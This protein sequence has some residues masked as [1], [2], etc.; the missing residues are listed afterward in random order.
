MSDEKAVVATTEDP[1]AEEI[2][3]KENVVDVDKPTIEEM[4][5]MLNGNEDIFEGPA[6]YKCSLPGCA[7]HSQL[8]SEMEEHVSGTGHGGYKSGPVQP[9]LFSEHGE[10][11]R[12][13]NVPLPDGVVTEKLIELSEL[14]QD[15]LNV[16]ENKK[17]ADDEFNAQL[18]TLDAQ[19]QAIARILKTPWTSEPVKCIWRII[20]GEN[21]RGLY[22]IDTGEIID[23]QPL[24]AEDR[25]AELAQA[26]AANAAPVEAAPAE[27]ISEAADSGASINERYSGRKK[28]KATPASE[29]A[30][31]EPGDE[32][33]DEQPEPD[34]DAA[35]AIV[36]E[37][38]EEERPRADP[39]AGE[40]E[41]A[42][43][44]KR[45]RRRAAVN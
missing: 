6:G 11:S 42:G 22:R 8:L 21:A 15:T 31:E 23:K 17:A 30:T 34:T 41:A 3:G 2:V 4:S 40:L 14:Y 38:Q 39:L 18:K 12:F 45:R 28:R 35:S 29:Q 19:M 1:T 36:D 37:M 44:G 13:V 24:T 27:P 25:A 9:E 10:V 26:E 16:K 20:E 33:E 43:N 32:T 7:F 5:G